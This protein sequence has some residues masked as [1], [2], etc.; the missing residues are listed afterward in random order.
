MKRCIDPLDR[1]FTSESTF[2]CLTYRFFHHCTK[3]SLPLMLRRHLRVSITSR[4]TR[5]CVMIICLWYRT[6]SV[7]RKNHKIEFR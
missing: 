2:Y 1:C 4:V 3:D 7:N 6:G 5:A